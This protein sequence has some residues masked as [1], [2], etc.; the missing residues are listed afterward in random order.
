MVDDLVSGTSDP[1]ES[2]ATNKKQVSNVWNFF[3]KLGK[4]K[5]GIEKVACKVL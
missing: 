3:K 4:D 2:A 5:D 1:S